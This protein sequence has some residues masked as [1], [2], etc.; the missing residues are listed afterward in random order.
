MFA[1]YLANQLQTAFSS[2]AG[3][4]LAATSAIPAAAA[5]IVPVQNAPTPAVA[6]LVRGI[7][8]G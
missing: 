1:P 3:A 6:A 2:F 8:M 5:A 7:A 4:P